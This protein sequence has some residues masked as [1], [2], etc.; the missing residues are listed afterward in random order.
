MVDATSAQFLSLWPAFTLPLTGKRNYLRVGE[1]HVM[2]QRQLRAETEHREGA[3]QK[4][5]ARFV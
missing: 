5:L 2:N 4:V 3:V 1:P